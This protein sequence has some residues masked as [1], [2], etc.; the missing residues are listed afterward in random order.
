M[1]RNAKITETKL[2]REDH[3]ILTF[4]L[5]IEWGGAACCVGGYCLD[6]YDRET[7]KRIYSA[8]GLEA[9]AN[10]LET[11]GVDNWEDLPGKLIRIYEQGR[12]EPIKRIGNIMEEKWFDFGAFF[13]SESY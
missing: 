4:Y 12:G 11:V 10:V 2:G 3:G 6:Y 1:I 9:I 5:A 13:K 8:K 7:E